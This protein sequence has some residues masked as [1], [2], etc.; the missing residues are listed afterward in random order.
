MR[1]L[2]AVA[3]LL[4]EA[5][6]PDHNFPFSDNPLL[7][8]VGI[9]LWTV[10]Y[11][12][13]FPETTLGFVWEED[14]KVIGNVTLNP[15]QGR[16]DRYMLCNIAVKPEYRRHG[17][18]RAMVQASTEHLRSIGVKTAIL[19]VRPNNPG[20]HDLYRSLGFNDVETRGDWFL[21][22]SRPQSTW[23]S[24][25]PLRPFRNSDRT[26]A[27]NLV[28]A[29]TPENTRAYHSIRD[30]FNLP[31]DDRLAE[32][33]SDFFIGQVSKRW[34]L[35]ENTQ[36]TALLLVRGQRL[37]M[38]HRFY[39]LVQPE[40]RGTIESQLVAFALAELGRFAQREIRAWATSTHP[41]WISALEQ[42]AFEMKDV[43]TLMSLSL[44]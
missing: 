14:G 44:Q 9:A 41:E 36:P 35:E 37:T 2:G 19:N 24:E 23:H 5:F 28:R 40:A 29:V 13:M 1:D 8:E 7:R 32:T 3:R 4:E 42:N 26:A 38:P 30:E 18:A 43:L 34:V 15:D 16:R 25:L 27:N 10:G 6:R 33:I 31:W 11:A 39:A 20:A 12:P 22:A 21:P 17:I